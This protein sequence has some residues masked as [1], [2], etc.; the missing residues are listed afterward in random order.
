MAKFFRF[1]RKTARTAANELL[2]RHVASDIEELKEV[3]DGI[4]TEWQKKQSKVG[5]NDLNVKF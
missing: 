4:E 3:V 1:R 5:L 2:Q